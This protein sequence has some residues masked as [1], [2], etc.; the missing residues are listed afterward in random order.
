VTI[1]GHSG[2]FVKALVHLFPDIGLDVKIYETSS[3]VS[4]L[5]RGEE[6]ERG[7]EERGERERGDRERG[8]GERR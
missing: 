7:R 5:L 1:L 6:K 4:Y 2:G 3:Y 8:E